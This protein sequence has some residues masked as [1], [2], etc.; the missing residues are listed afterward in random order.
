MPRIS[1]SNFSSTLLIKF[2][3]SISSLRRKLVVFSV[4]LLTLMLF[5]SC[6]LFVPRDCETDE[7][8]E[9][10]PTLE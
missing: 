2:C 8:P 1:V 10:V 5:S 6:A 7:L 3:M 4:I 9:V